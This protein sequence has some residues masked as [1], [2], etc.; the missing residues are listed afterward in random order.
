M[1]TINGLREQLQGINATSFADI[2]L[3][4]FNYQARHNPVYRRFLFA[5][6]TEANGIK[7]IT[8]IP[9]LP[10][11]F[12]KSHRIIT[13]HWI[14]TGY[15]ESSGTT[16]ISSSRHFFPDE[17]FYPFHARRNFEFFFGDIGQYHFFAL[18]PSYLE[19]KNSSLVTMLHHFIRQSS[20]PLSGFYLYNTDA[21]LN[22]ISEAVKAGDRKIML[23]GVTFALLDLAEK[24]KPDLSGA[25]IIET[26]GMKGRREEITREVLHDT[27]MR[28]FSVGQI[29]SEYGMTELFSQAYS[30][31]GTRFYPPPWMRVFIRDI[32]DPLT[33]LPEGKTG[34]I[35]I[36]D[37]ANIHSVAF[38]ET[39]DLGKLHT[40]GSFEILGRLDNTDIRGCN[41]MVE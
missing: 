12:F 35:N 34:G 22:R 27:L 41:L 6:G 32:Y 26:G 18:L 10:I 29:F 19:R 36:I 11:E 1:S 4:I 21:M 15:F 5:R 20:S 16:G 24:H 40:D 3:Q 33:L 8:E 25:I 14:P 37:L 13:G 2:A 7:S 9:F 30:K 23:W 38:I 39:G 28:A 31:G 17:E